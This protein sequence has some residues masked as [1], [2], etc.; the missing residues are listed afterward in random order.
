[1]TMIRRF[2]MLLMFC[3]LPALAQAS[4][5]R[6]ITWEVLAPPAPEIDNPF[7]NLSYDQMDTLRQIL[8][9]EADLEADSE[10]AEARAG[11]AELREQL[12]A[13]GLDVDALFAA[14]IKIM[15][16]REAAATAVNDD[17]IGTTVRLPGYVLP[18]EYK[19]RKAVEF[20]LVPTVGACIHTPPPPG[21]QIVHVMYPEG[22]AVD[23]LYTPVWITGTMIAQSSVQDVGYVDG[24]APVVVSYSMQPVLVEEYDWE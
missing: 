9:F 5:P 20:L 2:A 16:Y 18:L 7:E 15:D 19:D 24:Q 1:M 17:L 10:N 22:I 8:W 3:A 12:T 4:D 21:N 6:E 14:R 11:A 13:E 23:G